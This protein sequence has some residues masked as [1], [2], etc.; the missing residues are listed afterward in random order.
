MVTES[1][2]RNLIPGIDPRAEEE[3]LERL[4]EERQ[5]KALEIAGQNNEDVEDNNGT[6][7]DTTQ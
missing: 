1:T 4:K 3:E 6:D 7:E 5:Q 2:V